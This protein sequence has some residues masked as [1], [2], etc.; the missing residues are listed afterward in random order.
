MKNLINSIENNKFMTE[1]QKATF[2]E[3][4][5]GNSQAMALKRMQNKL[6][7]VILQVLHDNGSGM[8]ITEIQSILPTYDSYYEGF[9][10]QRISALTRQ[11]VCMGLVDRNEITTGNSVIIKGKKYPEKIAKF[12]FLNA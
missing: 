12:S 1:E 9:S 6:K 8:T 10:V 5:T 4:M 2:F 3:S 11:L 7:V